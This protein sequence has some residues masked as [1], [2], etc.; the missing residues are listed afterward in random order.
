MGK[1][2]VVEKWGFWVKKVG[3]INLSMVNRGDFNKIL[4]LCLVIYWGDFNESLLLI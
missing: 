3:K 4:L 1:A 2:K